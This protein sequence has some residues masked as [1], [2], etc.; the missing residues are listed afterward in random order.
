MTRMR[1]H[2]FKNDDK[3]KSKMTMKIKVLNSEK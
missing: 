1:T 3:N 2:L